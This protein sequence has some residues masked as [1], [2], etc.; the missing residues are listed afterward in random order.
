MG[1]TIYKASAGSGK[2]Y[3]LVREYLELLL[4]SEERDA[5]RRILVATF[6]NKATTE[7]RERIVREL[8]A[9]AE[10]GGALGAKAKQVLEQILLDYD[11]LRVQTIDSFFQEVV[12]SFT[13]ELIQ[14]GANVS[15]D[16]EL[17][18][19]GV[20]ELSVDQLLM[21]LDGEEMEWIERLLKDKVEEGERMDLR[22][23]V[24]ELAKKLLYNPNTKGRDL[25]QFDAK[26]VQ[27]AMDELKAKRT[28][29][30]DS[31]ED[32]F[33][34]L[35]EWLEEHKDI[36]QY[37]A[38]KGGFLQNLYNKGLDG[39]L[40]G[41]YVNPDKKIYHNKVN[42][43][44]PNFILPGSTQNQEAA[45]I[46]LAEQ[47]TVRELLQSADEAIDAHW[48]TLQLIDI[49]SA[50]LNLLPL[51]RGLQ[52]AV[53]RY[54]EEHNV[55]LIDEVNLLLDRVIAGASTPFIYEK[56][57][58][59]IRHYM[60]D[61]FQDTS[62]IQWDNFRSLLLD[63]IAQ[64]DSNGGSL[65]S[66][67][68]GDVKQSVYRW[69][70]TDS[71]LLNSGVESDP[72]F[73]QQITTKSLEDNWRSD[74]NIV[75]FNNQFFYDCY[76]FTTHTEGSIPAR[77][78]EKIYKPE[79]EKEVK[80]GKQYPEGAERGYVRFEYIPEKSG[81]EELRARLRETIV[82]LQRDEGYQAGDIAFLVRKNKE[83]IAIAE[84]L[85]DFAHSANE[86]ER[87]YFSFLSDEALVINN[88][89]VVRLLTS[90]FQLL[91]DPSNT[92]YQTLYEVA[93][94]M[95]GVEQQQ[96]LQ[97]I[98][99][100]GRSLL[101]VAHKVLREV[102]VPEGEELYVNAF[103]DLLLEYTQSNIA[104][105][106]Q[107]SDWWQ[108][109][110]I[111]KQIA[112]GGETTDKIKIITI[113]KAKGLEFPIVIMPYVGWQYYKTN[114]PMIEVLDKDE[115]PEGFL[116]AP[117]D[118][119]LFD[120]KPS[121]ANLNSLLSRRYNE[122][123]EDIY[124]DQLNLLYVAFTRPIHRL[125]IFTDHKGS[126]SSNIANILY[127]RLNAVADI[128]NEGDVWEFGQKT[129]KRA[130]AREHNEPLILRPNYGRAFT[131]IPPLRVSKTVSES[132]RYGITMHDAMARALTPEQFHV[133]I[134]RLG[135]KDESEI[136]AHF[137]QAIQDP[138]IKSW[139][140]PTEGRMIL[141]EQNIGAPKGLYRPDRLI[142]E[143]KEATVIDFKFAQPLLEHRAQVMDYMELLREM[144]YSVR[145][146]IW[147]WHQ[148]EQIQEVRT[149]Q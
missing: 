96:R 139:F 66:F 102:E 12:R 142:L 46:L 42:L 22:E 101:E 56:V 81:D 9:H 36:L 125:Y 107:F 108:R 122:I 148:K 137:D 128:R 19:D 103:L 134:Q 27:V 77:G 133:A 29:V 84:M 78:Y 64:N 147:Y 113:H 83:A 68:V 124:L 144:G 114:T 14:S 123:L 97:Q 89:R 135:R 80:Q 88:A 76:Q 112:M 18:R 5:Y 62:G 31:M 149:D 145:G 136:L 4:Q 117:L 90:L 39:I 45:D 40:K 32:S 72:G 126:G 65:E 63:A 20:I 33:G 55:L 119:Y 109:I 47:E 132:A 115:L 111:K 25:T 129:P 74:H 57:G 127:D 43:N 85:S 141:V 71:S 59:L 105:F 6:T 98:A 138:L 70:G 38:Q 104:T 10:K 8:R 58:G 30:L 61:E 44:K 37:S 23:K 21:R 24:V 99:G 118:F 82:T 54:Q 35:W 16:V 15:A 51:F 95:L 91:S 93:C 75:E 11:S 34:R 13:Y 48:Q 120:G 87:H 17:D 52:E 86:E 121:K 92:N 26:R 2:T 143:G 67:I 130:L 100:G 131:G 79:V 7:L 146:Y 140:T 49:L 28:A 3:T 60:I 53:K 50:H 73:D 94:I 69:R 1:L 116:Q 41:K 106:R 110:G